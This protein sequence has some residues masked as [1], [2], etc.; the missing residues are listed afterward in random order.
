MANRADGASVKAHG[1][2]HRGL[3]QVYRRT[4]GVEQFNGLSTTLL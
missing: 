3:S 2:V 4:D 1:S